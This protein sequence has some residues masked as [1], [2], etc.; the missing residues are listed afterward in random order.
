MDYQTYTENLN[1]LLEMVKKGRMTSLQQA[2]DKFE[3]SKST[4]TR[5]LRTMREQGY[6]IKYCKKT[7]KYFIDNV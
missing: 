5:M 7:Q 2:A 6:A 4:I 3:C 1:Y